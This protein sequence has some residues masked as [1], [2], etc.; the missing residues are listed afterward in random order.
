M[1]KAILILM[2]ALS[3]Q[4]WFQCFRCRAAR[5]ETAGV[6]ESAT[7]ATEAAT[8]ATEAATAETGAGTEEILLRYYDYQGGNDGMLNSF[9]EIIKIFEADHPGVK[10]EYKQYTVTTY[11]EYLKPVISGGSAPDMFAIYAGPDVVDIAGAGL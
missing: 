9:N 2:V 5:G 7:A 10:V 8:A 6:T 1:K 11:N 4:R 3:V